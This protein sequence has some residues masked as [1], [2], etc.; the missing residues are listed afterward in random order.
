M[1]L[2]GA[3]AGQTLRI[4]FSCVSFGSVPHRRHGNPSGCTRYLFCI[5]EACNGKIERDK[6]KNNELTFKFYLNKWVLCKEITCL[7]QADNLNI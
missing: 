2:L 6:K 5:L 4:S 1:S 7:P 3:N